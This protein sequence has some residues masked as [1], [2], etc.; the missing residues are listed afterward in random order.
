MKEIKE[1]HELKSVETV[2]K[3]IKYEVE[4]YISDLD[5]DD[6]DND[7]GDDYC[8]DDSIIGFR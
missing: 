8:D 4:D 3:F 2:T 6:D 1:N 7:V 5:F